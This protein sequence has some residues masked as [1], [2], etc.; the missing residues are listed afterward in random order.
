M[1][2]GN[3]LEIGIGVDTTDLK[4]G[5]NDAV[6]ALEKLRQ[7]KAV[8]LKAGLDVSAL[9][10][11]IN[12]A[13]AS[14][15]SLQKQ[16]SSTTKSFETLGKGTANG[17]NALMQFSRIAQDAPYGI[18]GIGNN[19]TATAEA[20]SYLQKQTGSTGGAL[21]ALA[22]SLMGSGGILLGISLLTTGLTLLASSGLSISDILDKLTGNFDEFGNA[23]KKASE[24]GAKSIAQEVISIK[25]LV[26][27][28]QDD[29][30]SKRD[31]LIAVDELQ[32][33]YPLYFGNL[34][35]EKI[36]TGDVTTET[37]LLTAALLSKAIAEKLSSDS[38]NIQLEVFKQYA[39]LNN[40]KNKTAQEELK[41][42]ADLAAAKK[43]NGISE[44]QLA[45]IR[46][47]GINSIN[48]AKEAEKDARAEI[49]KG[50]KALEQRQAIINKFTA[51][52]I[53]T[54]GSLPTEPK[55]P[56]I[57]EPKR[58][59]FEFQQGFI[60]G[61]IVAPSINF[62]SALLQ[63]D[64]IPDKVNEKLAMVQSALLD[65]NTSA[66]EI[67]NSSISDTFS[68][69]GSAIG[70]ALATGGNVL[71]AAGNE[72]LAGLGGIL[73]NLGAMAIEIGVGMLGIK[74]A[75][76]TLNPF[77]AIAAGVALVALGSI[78]SSKAS[79]IGGSM[80]GSGGSTSTSTG[81][82]ANTRTTS[83]SSG[84]SF[85][86]GGT[87]VFEISGQSLIG[88]L[89][90]TLDKNKRLGGSLAI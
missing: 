82:G 66:G 28:A 45:I 21:K 24:E 34:T 37:K 67:I 79:S 65:F 38:A 58:P 72:L 8:N 70:N 86:N 69:L 71:K 11:Q 43:I 47:K 31:R 53:A 52:G 68:G 81:N 44:S 87:V 14:L 7:Q 35:K 77:A 59:K 76:K 84:G 30:K 10:A 63:M 27:V 64:I 83:S 26:S 17:S 39:K 78:F 9:N 19:L 89:S 20:F 85:S 80:G 13:K 32:K 12:T 40:A 61:G 42:D 18:I 33:R 57:K 6:I 36:L 50:T 51:G 5:L 62:D 15:A 1:A 4:K 73:T 54:Q 46:A 29:A 55:A 74:A 25:A 23:V 56:K 2:T 22:S 49:I 60:P 41:L 88:V 90:N 75:L 16:N 3:K 48:T